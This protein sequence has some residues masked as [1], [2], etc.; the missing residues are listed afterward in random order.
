MFLAVHSCPELATDLDLVVAAGGAAP[1]PLVVCAELYGTVF[2]DQ[3]GDLV[4]ELDA[5]EVD[6]AAGSLRSDGETVERFR[7]GLPLAGADDPRR[8]H[9]AGQLDVVNV[10]CAAYRQTRTG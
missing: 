6:A 3:V 5:T 7:V 4:G 9:L 1:Y 8:K 10:V 2:D